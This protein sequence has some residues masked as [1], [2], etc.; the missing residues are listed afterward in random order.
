MHGKNILIVG[1][2]GFIGS[3]LANE[4]SKE[5]NVTVLDSFSNS[6]EENLKDLKI[7]IKNLDIVKDNLDEVV[8][9]KDII[10]H[11]ASYPGHIESVENPLE[12]LDVTVKGIINVLES[13]KKNNRKV[14]IV[15]TG[16]RAQYGEIEYLPVDEKH[17]LNP[18]DGQGITK[19]AAEQYLQLY[20]RFYNIRFVSLRLTN[21]YG[22][23]V[24][25]KDSGFLPLFIKKAMG[26][27]ILNVFGGGNNLRDFNYVDDVIKALVLV[28]EKD[29]ANNE[30][31]NLGG[32]V[33]S[34]LDIAKKII[35]DVGKGQLRIAPYPD[36]I[37][38]IEVGDYK[39]DVRKIEK[40]GWK[41]EV[42]FDEGL[43][44]IIDYYKK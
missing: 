25:K 31:Y 29:E 32:D 7:E 13:C 1:G 26:D 17:P 35:G 20:N 42:S 33:K 38:K 6:S 30:V 24:S 8:K 11:L 34:I 44:K 18:V 37:D 41:A 19:H 22:I 4:L 3:N 2:A 36:G 40:L 15:Y 43:G 27:E 14:K 16:T 9:D 10:Y 12:D 28:G 5:N 23:S 39:A 21:V